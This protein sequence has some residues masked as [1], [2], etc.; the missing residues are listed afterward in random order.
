MC[1][2]SNLEE[3]P[4][5]EEGEEFDGLF[6]VDRTEESIPSTNSNPLLAEG[7]RIRAS[8]VRTHFS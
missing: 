8:I 3:V 2:E 5:E 7:R 4:A 1:I 6:E